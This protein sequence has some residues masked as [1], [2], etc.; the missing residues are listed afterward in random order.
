MV[1]R[2]FAKS[3]Q[4]Q[5]TFEELKINVE[6]LDRV[7]DQVTVASREQKAGVGEVLRAVTDLSQAIE[8]NNTISQE[9]TQGSQMLQLK[10]DSLK[11]IVDQMT[12]LIAA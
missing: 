8:S 7:L 10:A 4:T 3:K 5:M 2:G 12:R 6:K 1:E 9:S 11:K